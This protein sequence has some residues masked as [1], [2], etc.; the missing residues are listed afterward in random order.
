MQGIVLYQLLSLKSW[1]SNCFISQHPPLLLLKSHLHTSLALINKYHGASVRNHKQ[2]SICRWRMLR[3][4]G[5]EW[6]SSEFAP[7]PG[8]QAMRDY[9]EYSVDFFDGKHG[10]LKGSAPVTHPSLIRDSFRNFY[11]GQYPFMFAKFRCC[12]DA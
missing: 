6:T 7:L 8:F 2:L 5:W 11:Q 1:P 9:P 4:G 10:V 12:R 3:S